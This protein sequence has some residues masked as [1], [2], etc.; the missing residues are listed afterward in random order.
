VR[1]TPRRAVFT[2]AA[3]SMAMIA[4]ALGVTAAVD[5]A[6][7]GIAESAPPEAPALLAISRFD[8][9]EH[10][11]PDTIDYALRVADA[12]GLSGLVNLGGGAA[13]VG[14]EAQLAAARPRGGRVLVFMNLDLEGCCR[15]EW[16][17]REAARL[18]AGKALGAR[19]LEVDGALAT[20]TAPFEPIWEASAALNLPVIVETGDL[21]ALA[22]LAERHPRITFVGARFGGGARDPAAVTRAMDRLP[23]LWVDTAGC[24][25]ILGLRAEE[26]RH[27]ILA[28]PDRV[29]FGTDLRYVESGEEKGVVLAAGRP[30]LLDRDLLG[31]RERSTF[32]IGTYAFFE[33]RDRSIPSPTPVPG[34]PPI[35]GMGL[36]R[37]ALE[38]LYHGN[39]ERLLKL[40]PIGGER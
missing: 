18:A 34:S 8:F 10:A 30:I 3:L 32:F 6:R 17:R 27:A 31:G 9:H 2:V 5:A 13:G 1:L 4:L 36:P 25:P 39:A 16:A 24:V 12:S 37:R 20:G 29:L 23:N 33:T 38:A 19:G 14:L 15:P 22:K 26:A 28:H 40:E 7:P 11:T 35:D 21:D